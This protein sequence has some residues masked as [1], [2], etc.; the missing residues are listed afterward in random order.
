[1]HRYCVD[2]VDEHELVPD[3]DPI[4]HVDVK[5][6]EDPTAWQDELASIL[7]H[8]L[9]CAVDT[10]KAIRSQS[11]VDAGVEL[12]VGREVYRS[13]SQTLRRIGRNIADPATRIS[14]VTLVGVLTLFM[15]EVDP[16]PP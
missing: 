3:L 9:I 4:N 15:A 2:E 6:A 7:W 16:C 13:K 12:Q 11:D 1:M 8:V 14:D 10:H 5:A